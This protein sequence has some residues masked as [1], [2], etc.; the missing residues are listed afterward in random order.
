MP[1]VC[2]QIIFNGQF[3][4]FLSLALNFGIFYSKISRH[5]CPL[6]EFNY[7]PQYLV[8]TTLPRGSVGLKMSNGQEAAFDVIGVVIAACLQAPPGYPR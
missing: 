4:N 7:I 3:T 8:T 2:I 1:P 6:A 5:M